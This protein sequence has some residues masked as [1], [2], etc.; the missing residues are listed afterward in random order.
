MGYMGEEITIRV[1]C[2]TSAHNTPQDDVDEA[3]VDEMRARMYEA[4]RAIVADPRY[5][6]VL[7]MHNL[8]DQGWNRCG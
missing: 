7:V 8:P 4:V 3:L 1:D 5:Q 2:R 6:S